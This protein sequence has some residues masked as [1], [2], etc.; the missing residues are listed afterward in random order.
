MSNTIFLARIQISHLWRVFTMSILSHITEFIVRYLWHAIIFFKLS[1]KLAQPILHLKIAFSFK[2]ESYSPDHTKCGTTAFR[3]YTASG[4]PG[5]RVYALQYRFY[6]RD[7][8]L[9]II[10]SAISIRVSFF[11]QVINWT[12]FSFGLRILGT[13][14]WTVVN[15]VASKRNFMASPPM[16]QSDK[17]T[18]ADSLGV[19]LQ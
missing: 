16:W 11:T 9:I 4:L 19:A 6:Y 17:M 18:A 1:F 10:Q 7:K 2:T 8:V 5:A 13:R 3:L 14:S 12:L 15:A